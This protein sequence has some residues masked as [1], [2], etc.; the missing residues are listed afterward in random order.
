MDLSRPIARRTVIADL[1]RGAFALAVLGVAGCAP[2][3]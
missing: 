1:G 2:S 3:M